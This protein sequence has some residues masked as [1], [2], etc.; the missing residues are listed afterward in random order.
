MSVAVAEAAIRTGGRRAR[1]VSEVGPIRRAAAPSQM[2]A[3]SRMLIGS[4]TQGERSKSS[5]VIGWRYM[6]WG[7]RAAFA[8]AFTENGAKSSWRA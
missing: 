8:C 2:P 7:L 1:R 4:A 3:E 6:A 5:T